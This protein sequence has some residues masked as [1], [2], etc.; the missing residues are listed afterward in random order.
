MGDLLALRQAVKEENI[1]HI[2]PIYRLHM[3]ASTC[4]H[5]N[6]QACIKCALIGVEGC[7]NFRSRDALC[8]LALRECAGPYLECS[9]F[10]S[11]W[12]EIVIESFHHGV[13]WYVLSSPKPT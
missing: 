9:D 6:V 2:D 10:P 13:N 12:D 7:I 3:R 1:K 8:Y 4:S 5:G 11:L